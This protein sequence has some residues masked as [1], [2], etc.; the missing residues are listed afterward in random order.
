M[1]QLKN[2]M[3]PSISEVVVTWEGIIDDNAVEKPEL[4]TSRTLMGFM[5]P[6]KAKKCEA[7]KVI[8]LHGQAPLRIPPIYDGT[9]LLVYRLFAA[10]DE[11]MP[12]KVEITAQAPDGPL[13]VDLPIEKSC[14]LNGNF[15]HQLAARKRIQDLVET[16][17]VEEEEEGV[18]REEMEKAVVELGIKY[19]LAS[20][21]TSFVGVD[22]KAAKGD[23]ELAMNTR[24]IKNQVPS[25]F[26]YG[27]PC[28]RG[29]Q[30]P[31]CGGGGPPAPKPPKRKK[32]QIRRMTGGGNAPCRKK[33]TTRAGEFM[34]GGGRST[35]DDGMEEYSTGSEES[36]GKPAEQETVVQEEDKLTSLVDLQSS[37]GHFKW[38]EV[39]TRCSGKSKDE[40]TAKRPSSVTNDDLWLTAVVIALLEAMTNEEDL[41]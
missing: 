32:V 35:D 39:I 6:K 37:D 29:M 33:S 38:G 10:K 41:W 24:D 16:V 15:V 26:G 5:K 17:Q 9:R 11:V 13:S 27:M 23:F 19:R 25:G 40:L 1:T 28:G 34:M 8:S 20:E 7:K 18:S 22:D 31:M 36:T 14:F 30:R 12:T 21:H 2:A 4:E 3:Q